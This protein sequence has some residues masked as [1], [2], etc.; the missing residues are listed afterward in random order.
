[1]RRSFNVS[2]SAGLQLPDDAAAGCLTVFQ[3]QGITA[4]M[5]PKP[6]MLDTIISFQPPSYGFYDSTLPLCLSLPPSFHMI[7]LI[8]V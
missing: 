5:S 7:Y 3:Q 1:M 8:M 6:Y 2:H 4:G